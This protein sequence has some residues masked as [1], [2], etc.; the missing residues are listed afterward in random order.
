MRLH[1]A[2]QRKLA[3]FPLILAAMRVGAELAAP[4]QSLKQRNSLAALQTPHTLD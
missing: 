2:A 4:A 3:V 1:Q